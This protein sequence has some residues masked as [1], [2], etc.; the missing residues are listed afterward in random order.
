[1]NTWLCAKDTFCPG[2]TSISRGGIILTASCLL[3][4]PCK[5]KTLS[6]WFINVLLKQI[7]ENCLLTHS[8]S[9]IRK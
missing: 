9:W 2:L 8:V 7:K 5:Q 1:M 3:I 4:L 6:I